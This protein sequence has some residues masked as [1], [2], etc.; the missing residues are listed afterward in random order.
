M[1]NIPVVVIWQGAHLENGEHLD[2]ANAYWTLIRNVESS[3]VPFGTRANTLASLIEIQTDFI[4]ETRRSELTQ[5]I[6][7]LDRRRDILFR[8]IWA[9]AETFDKLTGSDGFTESAKSFKVFISGYA[10][11]NKHSITEETDE[12]KG[13]KHDYD[14]NAAARSAAAVIGANQA[15]SELFTVNDSIED[16]WLLRQQE[17]VARKQA[18]DGETTATIRAKIN[19]V[20][21][22]LIRIVNAT[23]TISPN[24]TSINLA[25]AFD[26]LIKKNKAIIASHTK[27][28]SDPEPEPSPEPDAPTAQ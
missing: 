11:L 21:V 5:Y 10:E 15:L 25:Y 16:S 2:M 12:I 22:E 28:K 14:K 26:E 19:E 20:I 18:A 27:R 7:A 4:N 13:L 9:L 24:E 6:A 1:A 23:N 17:T 8:G 3:K